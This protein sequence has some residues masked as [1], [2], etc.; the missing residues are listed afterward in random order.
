MRPLVVLLTLTLVFNASN[1]V[2]AQTESQNQQFAANLV[3][4][5]LHAKTGD[6]VLILGDS[7]HMPLIDDITIQLRKVGAYA[8]SDIGNNRQAKMYYQYVPAKFDSQPP[9]DLIRLA[10]FATSIVTIDYPND[11]SVIAGVP[12]SRVAALNAAGVPFATYT[13][14]RGTPTVDVGNGLMPAAETAGQFG[15]PLQTL[16]SLFWSGV[17]ANYAQ[18]HADAVRM[19]AAASGS[20]TV[21]ITAPNGTN[22][23][24]RTVAGSA[25]MNDGTFSPA[26]RSRG[27][28]AMQKQLPAGDVYFLPVAA[29]ANGTIVYGTLKSFGQTLSGFTV[30]FKN[31]KIVSMTASRG[32]GSIR[33]FYQHGTAGR[34]QFGWA[35]FGVNRSMRVGAGMWGPGP[36]M[37]AGYVTAGIGTNLAQGGSNRSSFAFAGGIPNATVSVESTKVVVNGRLAPSFGTLTMKP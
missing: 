37:A 22:F 16:S 36:S 7:S 19:S 3:N 10:S 21:H 30:R 2:S 6:M 12:Q 17:N 1:A 8:I 26:N 14:K 18:I 24:F 13:L 35:D 23:T 28:A 27:G 32:L 34:D 15:V 33:N 29:S 11:P 5:I 25:V 9:D 20:H 4:N 31:G